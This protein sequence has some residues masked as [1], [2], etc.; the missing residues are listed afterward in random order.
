MMTFILLLFQHILNLLYLSLID[1]VTK[2]G[3]QN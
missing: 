2:K 1:L 3:I